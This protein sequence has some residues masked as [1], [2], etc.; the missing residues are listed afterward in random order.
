MG[1]YWFRVKGL[2]LC[3]TLEVFE[4]AVLNYNGQNLPSPLA[5]DELDYENLIVR[6]KVRGKLLKLN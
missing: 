3:A 4:I 2:G 6:G 5:R 1:N